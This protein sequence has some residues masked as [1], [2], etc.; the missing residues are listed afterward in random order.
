MSYKERTTSVVAPFS[1][2][3]RKSKALDHLPKREAKQTRDHLRVGYGAVQC[4]MPFHVVQ[5]LAHASG[6]IDRKKTPCRRHQLD[7]SG[8]D[9]PK[10][11][12]YFLGTDG[13]KAPFEN[14]ATKT[15][16]FR[17]T[18]EKG[19]NKFSPASTITDRHMGARCTTDWKDLHKSWVV[20][21]LGKDVCLRPSRYMIRAGYEN[22]SFAMV[23]WCL[24]GI[25]CD[26]DSCANNTS[27]VVIKKH[28][29]DLSM[30]NSGVSNPLDFCSCSYALD[31]DGSWGREFGGFFR[32][33]RIRML[34]PN[35][36]GN[37]YLSLSQLEMWGIL[38]E[39]VAL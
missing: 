20:V 29:N 32:K 39:V 37:A 26:R 34:K 15:A 30:Y 18:V 17:V 23:D 31:D 25:L 21:D 8:C 5:P 9:D 12:L 14:P 2:I 11:L 6:F 19:S 7:F 1:C 10:G 24:E 27:W 4:Q 36:D 35:V 3:M 33:F 13:L 22:G 38:E 16:G 28:V